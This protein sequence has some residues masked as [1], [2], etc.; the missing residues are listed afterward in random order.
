MPCALSIAVAFM[1]SYA[2]FGLFKILR[3]YFV[4]WAVVR[5][6]LDARYPPY[7]LWGLSLALIFEGV[8]CVKLR[9]VDGMH[10]VRGAFPHQ[11]SM[12]MAVNLVVPMM[13]VLALRFRQWL[14]LAAVGAGAVCIVLTLSRGALAIFAFAGTLTFFGSVWIGGWTRR[15]QYV[16]IG[17]MLG[18]LAILV[19][20]GD[21]IVRRFITA[22]EASRETRERFNEAAW[23]MT[24]DHPLGIGLNNYS[25]VLEHAGYAERAGIDG[26][27]VSGVVH[28]IYFLTLAEAGWLGLFAYLVL[29]L[30]PLRMAWVAIR[31][32]ARDDVRR[33][34]LLG[35]AVG[36][37]TMYLQGLLEW[38][39]RQP[40][41]MYLFFVVLALVGGLSTQ[42][43]EGRTRAFPASA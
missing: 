41:Q 35:A 4:Y 24:T 39:A 13:L 18:A 21:Q 19:K 10:Q 5:A 7:I 1:P 23:A 28:H 32:G 40:V 16:A 43:L 8:L 34:V 17:G 2:G 38:V 29:L 42:L 15:K 37:V 22:P 6:C 33:D 11:N 36:L 30:A 9:Y 27:G 25:H 12:G 26:Y 14:A 3:G 20:S 31:R